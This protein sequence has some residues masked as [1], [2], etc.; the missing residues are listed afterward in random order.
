MKNSINRR[1][2]ISAGA[3]AGV[4]AAAS[5][6]PLTGAI[7]SVF[8]PGQE[9]GGISNVCIFSKHLQWLDYREMAIFA[10][11][12]GFDGVDL[13]VRPGGHVE[14]ENAERDLPV[15]V[16]IIR[17]EGLEV[18]MMTSAVNDPDLPL[19]RRVLEAAAGQGIEYYRMG[20][21]RYL[22]E[23][24]VAGTLSEVK[25][26]M[27]KLARLNESVGIR[28]SY[29]NHAGNGY[30]GASIWDLWHVLKDLSPEWTGSQ[31]DL[32]HAMAESVLN[33]EIALQLVVDHVN[34]LAVKDSCWETGKNQEP[35]AEYCPLGQGFADFPSMLELLGHG[36][37][38]GPVSMHFEYPLGG[39][40]HG[41]R[42][43]TIS[44]EAVKSAMTKDLKHFR[45][46]VN[47]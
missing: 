24:P 31:F 1:E 34:T 47:I 45:R 12:I 41:G 25:V 30:F 11:E 19:S 2:F 36:S 29:Q 13:T 10:R 20:Y 8:R 27:E 3:A 21:Y 9:T 37:F 4:A 14:P 44:R 28:G 38:S 39:A 26:K 5:A 40:E 18:P 46:L 43:L 35:R 7:T 22:P 42:E 32:R 6:G 33:W 23:K 16:K 15:A 17:E